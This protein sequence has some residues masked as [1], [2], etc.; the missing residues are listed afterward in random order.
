[1]GWQNPV[2]DGDGDGVGAGGGEDTG[3]AELTGGA[4]GT[5]EG[6]GVGLDAAIVADVWGSTEVVPAG[7]RAR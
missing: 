1:M 7:R 4:L 5:T 3:G 6:D 2:G